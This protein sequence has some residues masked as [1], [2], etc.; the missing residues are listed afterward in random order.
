MKKILILE[1]D[2]ET[3]V[4]LSGL[5][6]VAFPGSVISH[7]ACLTEATDDLILRNSPDLSLIDLRL[8][9]GTGLD[10]LRRLRFLSPSTRCIVI[11]ALGDD[12]NVIAALAAGAEGYL[13]KDQP[14]AQIHAQLSS[15]SEGVPAISPS[16][17]R[18]IANHFTLTGPASQQDE[19]LSPRE[20]EVLSLIAR[21]YRNIDVATTL[22]ISTHTVSTH[23]KS[24]YRKLSICSRAEASWHATRLGI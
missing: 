4:W 5:V 15:L 18:R 13:L 7:A 24:I 21:G 23:I 14:D 8:P 17:A 12:S 1:D 3:F 22:D 11:T 16:I 10:F 6:G 19:P 2:S 20:S 9:D